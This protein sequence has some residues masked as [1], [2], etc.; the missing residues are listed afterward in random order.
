M[1]KTEFEMNRRGFLGRFGMALA[2][3][4]MAPALDLLA[5]PETP[6][7]G[8]MWHLKA[9]GNTVTYEALT[10]ADFD[11]VIKVLNSQSPTEVV[12]FTTRHTDQA[13]REFI[14]KHYLQ[15]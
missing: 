9:S 3:V 11:R 6:C 14:Q 12:Y 10:M 8:I 4:A 15:P 2:A 5:E 13:F 1:A 7:G